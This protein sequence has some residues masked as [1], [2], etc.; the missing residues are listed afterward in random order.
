MNS[1]SI[2]NRP[3][4]SPISRLAAALA[5]ALVLSSPCLCSP[6]HDAAKDGD[7]AR[8]KVLLKSSP[9]LVFSRDEDGETPL[10]WAALRGHGD[11]ARCLL[12]NKAD[13]NARDKEGET[14][15][16]LAS[17]NGHQDIVELLLASKPDL[18]AS[19]NVGFTAVRWAAKNGYTKI[20]ELL[21]QNGGQNE[22]TSPASDLHGLSEESDFRNTLT[23]GDLDAFRGFTRRHPS[24]L[25]VRLVDVTIGGSGLELFPWEQWSPHDRDEARRHAESD[26]GALGIAV[27]SPGIEVFPLTI[28]RASALGL[29]STHIEEGNGSFI[30][31]APSAPTNAQVYCAIEGEKY[32]I[33]GVEKVIEP[34]DPC[35]QQKANQNSSSPVSLEGTTWASSQSAG[36]ATELD[37]SFE[38]GGALIEESRTPGV[39][40]PSSTVNTWRQE[41]NNIYL[42][43]HNKYSEYQGQIF[44]NCMEGKGSNKEG[45]SWTWAAIER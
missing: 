26:G 19:D 37:F 45:E 41:G 29:R 35:A 6:I 13:V 24:S 38:V 22:D 16:L 15:L 5:V 17:R 11:V 30:A 28:E 25:S 20:E 9:R 42:T 44:G 43:T 23:K 1:R 18:N 40:E 10:H 31:T 33:V 12:A 34:P 3:F 2:L 14:P 4:R 32:R 8:V 27:V 7:L 39:G 36:L 21:R